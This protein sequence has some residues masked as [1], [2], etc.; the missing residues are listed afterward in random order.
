MHL[1]LFSPGDKVDFDF[2]QRPIQEP[3]ANTGTVLDSPLVSCFGGAPARFGCQRRHE[4][5]HSC[6][7]GARYTMTNAISGMCIGTVGC[8][9]SCSHT[10]H[11]VT[12]FHLLS[13]MYLGRYCACHSYCTPEGNVLSNQVIAPQKTPPLFSAHKD[14]EDSPVCFNRGTIHIHLQQAVTAAGLES[15]PSK[16]LN[17]SSPFHPPPRPR[18]SRALPPYY[19]ACTVQHIP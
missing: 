12:V 1:H 13:C 7:I 11:L 19:Y 9:P 17:S 18:S 16:P 6:Q 5:T 4:Y 8:R 3:R 2:G 14:L 15:I 10:S